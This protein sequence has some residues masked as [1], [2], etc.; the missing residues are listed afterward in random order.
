M[1]GR[2]QGEADA[3]ART[4]ARPATRASLADDL[5]KLGLPGG[6]T[7]LVH[8][9]LSALGWV[10]GGPEAVVLALED[11][12][13]PDGTIMMPAYSL[14]AP[15]PSVWKHPPVPE[16]WWETIRTEWPP[17]DLHLSPAFRLGAIPETFRHQSGTA[18]SD[19]P[20]D[21]FCARGP[22]ATVL[23]ANHS[24]DNGLG[25]GSPLARLYDRDG[26]VLLLGVDHSSN[27]SIHLAEYRSDWPGKHPSL[28]L[29]ARVVRGGTEIP[30]S[31]R[32]LDLNSDDFGR[33]GEE[34]ERESHSVRT[35]RV[36]M[37]PARLMA[38]RP[39]VDFAAQWMVAH[40]P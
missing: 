15:E 32:N 38:Q 9:S 11:M 21:S 19:H 30:L 20:N 34:Y 18:R 37:G 35:A 40:R 28:P 36:G 13:G 24:L 39:L 17:F 33:L 22:N 16:A 4:G 1:T 14:S 2:Y 10:V 12:V 31:F 8:S 23:L 6:S 29:R 5:R 26:F 7:V 27:S 3:I 25:E